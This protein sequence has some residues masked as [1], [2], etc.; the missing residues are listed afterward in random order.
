MD[1]ILPERDILINNAHFPSFTN[2]H[3]KKALN[4]AKE[5]WNGVRLQKKNK[6]R[7][8]V[9]FKAIFNAQ[10]INLVSKEYFAYNVL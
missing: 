6:K 3:S 8:S 1:T 10:F 9:S 7:L 2:C 5:V 4:S